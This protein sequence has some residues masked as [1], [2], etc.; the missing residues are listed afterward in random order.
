MFPSQEL[1]G[2]LLRRM[3]TAGSTRK[4][5]SNKLSWFIEGLS[6]ANYIKQPWIIYTLL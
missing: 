3:A 6:T 4:V 2:D 5:T 1:N